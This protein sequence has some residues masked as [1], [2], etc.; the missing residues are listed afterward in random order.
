MMRKE[1]VAYATEKMRVFVA[2][3]EL[4]LDFEAMNTKGEAPI[5]IAAEHGHIVALKALLEPKLGSKRSIPIHHSFIY[6]FWNREI[7]NNCD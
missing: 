1:A 2:L 6:S 4:G 5:H 3:L 7:I